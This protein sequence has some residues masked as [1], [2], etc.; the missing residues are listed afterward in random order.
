MVLLAVA[1]GSLAAASR[2]GLGLRD[3]LL[4][5]AVAFG[6]LAVL[7][8]E[9][10]SL[11]HGLTAGAVAAA[12]SLSIVLASA[13]AFKRGLPEKPSFPRWR[14][15]IFEGALIGGGV[16]LAGLIGLT[17]LKSAPNSADAMAYHLPRIVYW[18]QQSSVEF[19]PTHYLNQIMLQPFA[20]YLTLQTW[21]L[22]TG[23]S[24]ANLPQLCAYLVC[25]LGVSLIVRELGGDR[26]A[27]ALSAAICATLPN[28]I[29]QA[30]GAKN[31]L[32][33][34]AGLTSFFY[35]AMRYGRHGAGADLAVASAAGALALFTKGTAYLFLPPLAIA[36]LVLSEKRGGMT[37]W[38]L[39]LGGA[40]ATL[41]VNGP[42]YFRNIQLSGSPLGFDSSFADGTFRWRNEPLSLRGALSNALR[43]GSDQVGGRSEAWNLSVYRLV[44]DA[45]DLIGADPAD[46]GTTWRWSAFEPPRNANHETNANNRLHLALCA[47]AVLWAAW[48]PRERKEM[49]VLAAA[50]LAAFLL[51]CFY[52]KWQPFQA[53]MLAPL[54]V[55][56][57]P[58]AGIALRKT[59]VPIQIAVCALL[60]D[61][62]RLPATENWSRP[63][64]GE[65][66]ILAIPRR[67]GYFAD[68][69]PWEN[70]EAYLQSAAWIAEAG[71]TRIGFDL[72][73]YQIEYPLMAL[74]RDSLPEARFRHVNVRNPSRALAGSEV[75]QPCAVVCMECGGNSKKLE[76]YRD[77]GPPREKAGFLVFLK[78]GN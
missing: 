51:F 36:V 23:D 20:E 26:R 5:G 3:A 4:R 71:C 68:L 70:R 54:F 15:V 18:I 48:N 49:L 9:G 10:L 50:L 34:A 14:E 24:Y 37:F 77:Y 7:I 58:V 55:L 65:R 75:W 63:L 62:A 11:F 76:L 56:A 43:H 19:F 41:L 28:A 40:V 78:E 60:F 44:L 30:S 52:L 61:G 46:K 32:V 12:W 39:A 59:P 13:V 1:L 72:T 21:L 22:S 29:L 38:N 35:F 64:E 47:L 45:H 16:V 69:T 57:D 53:R 73:E 74:L 8:A 67:D 2:A 25:I 31:D 27:Q 6:A 17:A 33:V 66:S 42:L